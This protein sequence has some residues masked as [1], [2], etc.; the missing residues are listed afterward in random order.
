VDWPDAPRGHAMDSRQVQFQAADVHGVRGPG[1]SVPCGDERGSARGWWR[2]RRPRLRRMD[3]RHRYAAQAR[4][5]GAAHQPARPRGGRARVQL[6]NPDAKTRA[7]TQIRLTWY[8]SP[9]SSP[10]SIQAA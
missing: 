1:R 8:E 5:H 2:T 9:T 4:I 6:A 3:R 10:V 7:N